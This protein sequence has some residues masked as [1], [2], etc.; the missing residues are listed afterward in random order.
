MLDE[1]EPALA[2]SY[3]LVSVVLGFI[4]VGLATN[5]VRRARV[6]T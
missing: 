6:T 1:R 3:A 5:L 4:A 2:V